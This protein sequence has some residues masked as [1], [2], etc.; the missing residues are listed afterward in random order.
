MSG[1]SEKSSKEPAFRGGQA[2]H[3][4]HATQ[5]P[6]GAAY[7]NDSS[8]SGSSQS[9]DFDSDQTETRDET[10]SSGLD[11]P[12]SQTM[13]NYDGEDPAGGDTLAE[14]EEDLEEA[15]ELAEEDLEAAMK[16]QIA[17]HKDSVTQTVLQ[18]S[19][20]VKANLVQV[21]GEST[22]F[23]AKDISMVAT[24]VQVTL[25]N[26]IK[27]YLEEH[28]TEILSKEENELEVEAENEMEDAAEGEADADDTI[29]NMRQEE[30]MLLADLKAKVDDMMQVLEGQ[31]KHMAVVIAK[32]ALR[33]MLKKKT[34]KIYTVYVDDDDNITKFKAKTTKTT[35]KKTTSAA[36]P[37][38]LD[39]DVSA[40]ETSNSIFGNLIDEVGATPTGSAPTASSWES[41]ASE[42]AP[43]GDMSESMGGGLGD[44]AEDNGEALANGDEEAD[45]QPVQ[46]DENRPM[47]PPERMAA[48][49]AAIAASAA[50]GDGEEDN[51]DY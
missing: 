24:E 32:N 27:N 47:T 20:E 37:D 3:T 6:A 50:E 48:R 25:N 5:L 7:G 35:K 38:L 12:A 15:V 41:G 28:T 43:Q 21:M 45:E 34:G 1:G 18:A 49:D 9:Y 39:S 23:V 40:A 19:R 13:N 36:A 42:F 44:E 46:D 17:T 31:I 26:E 4:T 51:A 8:A 14:V 16:S 10:P 11:D 2:S 22:L 29:Q 30:T 33:S